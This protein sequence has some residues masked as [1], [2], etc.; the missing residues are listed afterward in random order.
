MASLITQIILGA[1]TGGKIGWRQCSTLLK[2]LNN[3]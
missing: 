1:L 3:L 2:E